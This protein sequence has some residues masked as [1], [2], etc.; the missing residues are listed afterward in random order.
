MSDSECGTSGFCSMN[1]KD[2]DNVGDVCDNCLEDYNPLQEDA[3]GDGVG[4]IC[5]PC[6]A[7]PYDNCDSACS[8]LAII[9]PGGGY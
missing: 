3:D 4:D 5:D 9:G 8:G 6:P 7:D 1:Q 2:N